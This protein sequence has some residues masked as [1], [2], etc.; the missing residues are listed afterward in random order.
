[1]GKEYSI[2]YC[3]LSDSSAAVTP[4]GV[5]NGLDHS[6]LAFPLYEPLTD[7]TGEEAVI[8]TRWYRE[9]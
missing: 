5:M 9:H 7:P 8:N 6:E 4:G 2:E 3:D 1:M